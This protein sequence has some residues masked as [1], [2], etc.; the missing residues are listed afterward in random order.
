MCL[1]CLRIPCIKATATGC[2]W[3]AAWLRHTEDKERGKKE[4]RRSSQ[5]KPWSRPLHNLLRQLRISRKVQCDCELKRKEQELGQ[6]RE[7]VR[8]MWRK[9]WNRWRKLVFGGGRMRSREKAP[10]LP[11]HPPPSLVPPRDRRSQQP[12]RSDG[13]QTTARKT[14]KAN[15]RFGALWPPS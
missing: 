1:S 10:Y 11:W 8:Q 9:R 5:V 12:R 15:S 3:F 4:G 2:C 6:L 14:G 13:K 7:Q